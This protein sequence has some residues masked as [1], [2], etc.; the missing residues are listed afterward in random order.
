MDYDTCKCCN[1]TGKVPNQVSVGSAMRAERKIANVSLRRMAKLIGISAPYL[2]DLELGRRVWSE[3]RINE[4]R[5]GL[6][7]P[8]IPDY[9]GRRKA[10]DMR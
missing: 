8:K 4:Y 2:S 3:N 1:G 6:K 9:E 10:H 5:D 7:L